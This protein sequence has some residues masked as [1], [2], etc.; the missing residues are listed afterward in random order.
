MQTRETEK[1]YTI[2]EF[3]CVNCKEW[4]ETGTFNQMFTTSPYVSCPK[5]GFDYYDRD[6]LKQFPMFDEMGYLPAK[7]KT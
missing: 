3:Q 5:C 4:I 7:D 2:T 6:T 1:T